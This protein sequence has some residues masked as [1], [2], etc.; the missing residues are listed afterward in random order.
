MSPANK[1][2]PARTGAKAAGGRSK[3]FLV[4]HED[5][6]GGFPTINRNI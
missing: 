5:R 4:A 1:K 3:G 2:A 6:L